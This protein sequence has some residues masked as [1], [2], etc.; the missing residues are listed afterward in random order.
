MPLGLEEDVLWE[1]LHLGANTAVLLP[2]PSAL[3]PE[4]SEQVLCR[5]MPATI[6]LS[7]SLPTEARAGW[8][9]VLGQLTPGSVHPPCNSSA[10]R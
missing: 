10:S 5:M 4:G 8:E 6:L 7:F 1:S 2:S 9:L 3:G